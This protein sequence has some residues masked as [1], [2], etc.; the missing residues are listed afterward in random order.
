MLQ[1]AFRFTDSN[2]DGIVSGNELSSMMRMSGETVS[3][4]EAKRMQN[5]KLNFDGK[6]QL[7]LSNWIKST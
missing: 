4:M 2:G 7:T 3:A 6:K 1:M 5:L